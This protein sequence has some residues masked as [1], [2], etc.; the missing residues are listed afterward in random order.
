MLQVI[1]G[2][3]VVCSRCACRFLGSKVGY[4]PSQPLAAAVAKQ[5]KISLF[6]P[7]LITLY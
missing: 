5:G 2:T 4:V 1:R 7:G 3:A 6:H